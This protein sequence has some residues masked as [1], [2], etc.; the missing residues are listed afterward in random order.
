MTTTTITQYAVQVE[1][2]PDVWIFVVGENI[3]QPQIYDE[4]GWAQVA[5]E[6]WNPDHV[7]VV[8]RTITTTETDW[9]VVS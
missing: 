8:T 7:R 3:D 9:R 2:E 1:M 4:L 6:I 5:A